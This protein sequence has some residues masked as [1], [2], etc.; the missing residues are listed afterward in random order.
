MRDVVHHGHGV[1]RY[2][3]P[4]TARNHT[5]QHSPQSPQ[6]G[7]TSLP[8]VDAGNDAIVPRTSEDFTR[9]K[10]LRRLVF[11]SHD[12]LK[13]VHS[14]Y[15]REHGCRFTA[16]A[17][18]SSGYIYLIWLTRTLFFPRSPAVALNPIHITPIVLVQRGCRVC[19]SKSVLIELE[20]APISAK[21]RRGHPGEHSET[22]GTIDCR[23]HDRACN[24]TS[25]SAC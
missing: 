20:A 5:Q 10:V 9:F 19:S 17:P 23:S 24:M 16:L 7:Y 1:G 6:R 14:L 3:R 13:L 8:A 2:G 4:L 12:V 22:R 25:P 21:T 11:A 15:S 18:V